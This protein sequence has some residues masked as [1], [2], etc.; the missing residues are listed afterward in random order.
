MLCYDG[1]NANYNNQLYQIFFFYC[2]L[3]WADEMLREWL[4]ITFTDDDLASEETILRRKV[5]LV[6]FFFYDRLSI[7]VLE[8]KSL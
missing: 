1:L 8:W 6:S 3:F 4:A 2:I 7:S 5:K